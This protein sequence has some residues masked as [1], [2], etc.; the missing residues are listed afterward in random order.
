MNKKI[1]FK[2]ILSSNVP[3]IELCCIPDVNSR[4]QLPLVLTLTH[5]FPDRLFSAFQTRRF[6]CYCRDR[7]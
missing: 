6:K 7:K 5:S 4:K 3:K 1:T 2:N